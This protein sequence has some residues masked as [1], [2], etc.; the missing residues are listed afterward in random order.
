MQTKV[1]EGKRVGSTYIKQKT[2]RLRS[3]ALWSPTGLH[4]QCGTFVANGHVGTVEEAPAGVGA[5]VGKRGGTQRGLWRRWPAVWPAWLAMAKIKVIVN[6][7]TKKWKTRQC[8][9]QT[10]VAHLGDRQANDASF[11]GIGPSP[12][13]VT[14]NVLI[15]D[16]TVI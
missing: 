6:V 1:D 11:V 13:L 14:R 8:A 2:R 7:N 4:L 16:K 15:S 5:T 9:G 3:P 10:T 12:S